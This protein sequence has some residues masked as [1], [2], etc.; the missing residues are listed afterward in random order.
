MTNNIQGNSHKV[1][2]CFLNRN[3]PSQKGIAWHIL[4]DERAEKGRAH[5][6]EYST[7]QDSPS[8][9]MKKSK[10]FCTRKS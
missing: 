5:N 10:Y 3:F 7:E 4:N 8:D 2:S 1:I 6:Q 9:L